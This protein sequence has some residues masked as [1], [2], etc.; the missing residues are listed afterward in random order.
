MHDG[1]DDHRPVKQMGACFVRQTMIAVVGD[2]FH[3]LQVGQVRR[4]E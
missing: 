3:R 2:E 4:K 1:E